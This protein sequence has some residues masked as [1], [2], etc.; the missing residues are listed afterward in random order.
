VS[1]ESA[2]SIE[3]IARL[4]EHDERAAAEKLRAAR[5]RLD[6][7]RLKL[8]TVQR[9][10]REYSVTAR[11][12]NV[13]TRLLAD[14]QRFRIELERSV[15]A[16]QV[17]VD[18]AQ[19]QAEAARAHWSQVRAERGAMEKLVEKREAAAARRTSQADQRQSDEQALGRA[20]KTEDAPSA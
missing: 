7:E 9:Y 6:N 2:Q 3:T 13:Q 16:Q 14:R 12:E 15:E 10:L 17:A 1:R 8:T 4:K 18:R 11:D 5:E 20:V 19:A